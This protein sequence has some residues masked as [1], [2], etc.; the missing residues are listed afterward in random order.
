MSSGGV[1]SESFGSVGSYISNLR[2]II[3]E[4]EVIQAFYSGKKKEREED[5][6]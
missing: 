5:S 2:L 3:V 6:V 1:E 4:G